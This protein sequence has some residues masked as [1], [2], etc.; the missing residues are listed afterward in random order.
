[1]IEY[2][3]NVLFKTIMTSFVDLGTLNYSLIWAAHRATACE[4]I[5]RAKYSTSRCFFVNV[6][7]P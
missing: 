7:L 5:G 1:M 6:D 3:W 4:T 2:D